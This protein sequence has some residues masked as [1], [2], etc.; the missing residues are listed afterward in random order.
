MI[1]VVFGLAGAALSARERDFFREADPAG[2]I[3]FGRN[4]VDRAQLR[5]LTD[6]LRTL[7]GRTDLPILI[8]QEGGRVQRMKPPEWP[9]FPPGAV[10][11]RLW[12]VAPMS[13]MEAARA[14][15][16]ALALTLSEVGISVDCLPL[17][18]V[19]QPGA[20]DVIG[21][22]ALGAEP[23]RVASIGRAILDGLAAGGVVGVMKHMP[24]HG[25]AGVD[26][27][28]SLPVVEADAAALASDITPFQRLAD[29][30]M[31]MTAHVVYTA[32]DPERPATLSPTVIDGVIRKQIGFD[33]FLFTDDIDMKALSGTP[34]EKAVAA[35]AAG[36][37]AVL[38]CWARMDEMEAVAAVLPT[39]AAASV[40]R[41]DRAMAMRSAPDAARLDDLV[42]KRDALLAL[43]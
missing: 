1:P 22:R 9:V 38:D 13:A 30:P 24:G 3:L 36:C 29:A 41:L 10:F 19:R 14:H 43:A 28:L 25:R 17:L 42:A 26:S 5:A 8:D 21:D 15:A 2:Y 31:G 27:H 39:M 35:I 37:D 23:V 20:S 12:E 34:A 7:H 6:D 11:D 40:D 18:D 33:G 16:E 4:V 32:W